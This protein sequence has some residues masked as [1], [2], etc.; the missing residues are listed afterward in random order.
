MPSAPSTLL[1]KFSDFGNLS[2][3]RDHLHP[4][5]ICDVGT[6]DADGWREASLDAPAR[7]PWETFL[8][9]KDEWGGVWGVCIGTHYFYNIVNNGKEINSNVRDHEYEVRITKR[10][11]NNSSVSRSLGYQVKSRARII[12]RDTSGEVFRERMVYS[13]NGSTFDVNE[14]KESKTALI[15]MKRAAAMSVLEENALTIELEIYHDYIEQEFNLPRNS[16]AKAALKML[17]SG[18]DADISFIVGDTVIYAHK[19]ILKLNAELLYAFVDE[20]TDDDVDSP[21]KV[22]GTTAE[23]FRFVLTYIYGDDEPDPIFLVEHYEEIIDVADKYGIIGL[24]LKAEAAKISSLTIDATSDLTEHLL[25]EEELCSSSSDDS[26][27]DY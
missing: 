8:E 3:S 21:V 9:A 7:S 1:F 12:V 24:K 6:R 17:K 5:L 27:I 11:A 22:E 4:D 14:G 16:L 13:S 15:S 23:I 10:E 26:S 25:A 18:E 20:T 2:V 19:L